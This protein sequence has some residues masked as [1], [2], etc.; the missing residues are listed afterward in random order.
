MRAYDKE[1]G[2][3]MRDT[4][5]VPE[6]GRWP[7]KSMDYAATGYVMSVKESASV[8]EGEPAPG[9]VRA[10]DLPEVTYTRRQ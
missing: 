8:T 5:V 7:V 3:L 10:P 4:Y 1:T 2:I 6:W 9:D